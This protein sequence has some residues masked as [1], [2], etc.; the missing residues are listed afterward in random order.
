Q[1]PIP[2]ARGLTVYGTT[3]YVQ[4]PGVISIVDVS[5]PATPVVLGTFGPGVFP[6]GADVATTLWGDRLVVRTSDTN[7]ARLWIYSLA[8]PHAPLLESSGALPYRFV[9]APTIVG[10]TAYVSAAWYFY[11]VFSAQIFEQHG[12]VFA[13]DLMAP[14]GPSLTGALFTEPPSGQP[15]G[16]DY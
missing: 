1:V 12:D 8:D 3:A 4:A 15:N 2:N 5:D 16:G 10:D 13:M 7:T 9:F 14:G 11:N 6:S